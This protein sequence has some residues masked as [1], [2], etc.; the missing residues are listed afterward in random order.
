MFEPHG[1]LSLEIA[2]EK[3]KAWRNEYDFD[4]SG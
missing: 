3:I 2:K 1:C 4:I